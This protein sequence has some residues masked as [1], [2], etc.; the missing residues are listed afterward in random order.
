MGTEVEQG[1]FGVGLEVELG[2]VSDAADALA[3]VARRWH[4]LVEREVYPVTADFEGSGVAG[5]GSLTIITYPGVPMGQHWAL[6]RMSIAAADPTAVAAGVAYVFAGSTGQLVGAKYVDRAAALP[7]TFYWS[8][9][10]VPLVYPET[11]TVL[12]TTPTN[13]TTYLVNGTAE[14]APLEVATERTP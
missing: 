4:A 9:Y 10:Q 2:R 8:R 6:R 7:F 12:I 3:D 5:A 14:Q 11:I 13:G 1:T